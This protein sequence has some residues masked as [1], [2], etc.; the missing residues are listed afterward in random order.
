LAALLRARHRLEPYSGGLGRLESGRGQ[1]R[2]QAE[3]AIH[4]ASIRAR[5]AW[6]P[7]VIDPAARGRGQV[8]G[9]RLI[10]Q[11][12]ELGLLLAPAENAVEAGLYAVWERLS[13]WPAVCL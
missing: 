10:E 5:G 9:T 1:G 3:P 7:G 8:D 4:A 12:G 11:Y 6:I 2:A 13:D